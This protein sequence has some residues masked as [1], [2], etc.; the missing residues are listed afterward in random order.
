[1]S[2]TFKHTLKGRYPMYK[3]GRWTVLE[4]LGKHCRCV[5][6]CGTEKMV[7]TDNL[8]R[9]LTMSCGCLKKERTSIARTVDISGKKYGMLTVIE[10][11]GSMT[12]SAAWLCQCECGNRKTIRGTSLRCGDTKSCGC[13][14][15]IWLSEMFKKQ[16]RDT[17][18]Y[19][20]YHGMKIRCY[21]KN[22][23][24]FKDYGG[25]GIFICDRWLGADGFD[26]FFSDMG[27][28]PTRHHSID[29]IN[30][31]CDYSPENCRWAT[32]EEQGNN[33]RRNVTL[34]IHGETKTI[35]QWAKVSNIKYATIRARHK[36]GWSDID[37]V[38]HPLLS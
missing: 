19:K 3:K 14:S 17:V 6:D 22:N 2:H 20:I 33:T 24:R 26:T 30:N 5:C 32:N 16:N 11:D 28:R 13:M 4:K 35:G 9:N 10:R 37:C 31:D 18:E 1:M 29:R 36:R 7:N 27:R 12:G 25:R 38:Q 23:D 15:F 34:T 8:K 21:G